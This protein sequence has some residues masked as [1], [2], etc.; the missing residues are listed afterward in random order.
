MVSTRIPRPKTISQTDI[1]KK[2]QEVKRKE[3]KL[4]EP[5]VEKPVAEAFRI[6]MPEIKTGAIKPKTLDELSIQFGIPKTRFATTDLLNDLMLPLSPRMRR[7]NIP[8]ETYFSPEQA[9]SLGLDIPDDVLIKMSPLTEG[10]PVFTVVGGE[11]VRA[12]VTPDM[13]RLLQQIYPE[14]FGAGEYGLATPMSAEQVAEEIDTFVRTNPAAF[15]NDLYERVGEDLGADFLRKLG[16]GESLI[17][18]AMS[19]EKQEEQLN[20]SIQNVFPDE[21]WNLETLGDY[22]DEDPEA[23]IKDLQSN[24]R[25]SYQDKRL[26]LEQIGFQPADINEILRWQRNVITYVDGNARVIDIDTETMN[27]Y[28]EYGDYAGKYNYATKSFTEAPEKT[29]YQNQWDTF[30]FASNQYAEN[31]YSGLLNVTLPLLY[32]DVPDGFLGGL[33]EE[34]TRQNREVRQQFRSLYGKVSSDYDKWTETHPEQAPKKLFQEGAFKHPELLKD[35]NYWSYEVANILPFMVAS[36]G[37]TVATGGAGAP[38]VVLSTIGMGAVESGAVYEDL[39]QAGA[40]PDQA[41]GMAFVAGG[42]IGAL[43]SVGKIPLL[44]QLNAGL[45]GRFKK[46][47]GTKL[48]NAILNN[49]ISRFGVN[50]TVSQAAEVAT[51]IAQEIVGNVAVSFFDENRS[52]FENIPDIAVKTAVA[53]L[54]L[55]GFGAGVSSIRMVSPSEQSG[56]TDIAKRAAGWVKDNKGNWFETLGEEGGFIV[57]G[58]EPGGERVTEGL[59]QEYK[60]LIE[61]AEKIAPD[62]P[63]VQ[64]AKDA[65]SKITPE[66]QVE[67]LRQIESVEEELKRIVTPEVTQ[68]VGMPEAGIQPSMIEEISAKEVR[69]KGKGRITQISMDDQMRLEEARRQAEEAPAEERAAYEAQAEI[70]S[71][72]VTLETDPVANY[73][74]KMGN[75]NVG[76][77]SLISIREQSFPDYFTVKQAR[78]LNPRGNVERYT[79]KGT[80][81]YNKVPRDVVLDDLTKEF[82]MTPDEIADRVMA[83]RRERG[84]IRELDDKITKQMTEKPLETLPDIMPAEAFENMNTPGRPKYTVKQLDALNSVF[85][86]Y[87]NQPSVLTAWELTREL[88]QETKAGRAENLKAR[89]QQLIVNEGLGSEQALKQAIADTMSGELPT[90]TTDYLQGITEDM[91][92]ALFAKV[93]HTLKN[94]PFEMMSTVTALTNA[95]AGRAIPR[96]PGVRGGSAYSRLER[97][98]GDQP[99]VIRAIDKMASE[100]KSLEDIV[101]GMFHEVGREP[102]PVD[103]ETADYLRGLSA[104]VIYEPSVLREPIAPTVKYE[105]PIEDAIKQMPLFPP[106]AREKVIR[107]LKEAGMSPVDIGNFLRANK[108]SFDFSFWRQQAPLIASHPVSFVQAN[109]EAW[110][111]IWSQKSAEASWQRITR[112]SLYQIYE[113]C[114]QEGGDFLRPLI[115]P[116]GTAQW[117]GTE[118]FGYLTQERLIPRLTA[119]LP[120]I[121]LSARSFETGTNVHN[122]LIFKSHYEAMLRLGEMYA[123]GK[124]KLKPGESFDI[125]KEMVDLSKSLA[126]FSARGSL[127][128]FSATAPEL[129]AFF[130]APRASIGRILSVKDLVSSNPRVRAFAWK[131]ATTFVGV[132]GGMVLLGGMMGWWDVETDPRSAEYMSVRLGNT[133]IDPW[134]GY[135]QFLVFFVRAITKT[136]VSSVTGAEYKTDPLDLMQN[137]I[138]GKASPFASTILDFWKGKNFVGEEVDVANKK[139]WVERVAPFSIWDIYEA[140]QEDPETAA[141]IAIPAI[142]GAGVQTY[143]GEWRENFSKLG[144]PKYSENLAYGIT[145]PAYDTGDFYSDHSNQFTGVDPETLTESKGFPNYIKALA[146]AKVIKSEIAKIPSESLIGLKGEFATYY[147]MWKDREKIVAAD[148]KEALKE[149]DKKYPKAEL[150]NFS[151]R[152]FALLNQYW[153]L[154]GQEQKDFLEEH[155]TEIGVNLRQEYLRAHPKENA[156]LAVWGQANILTKEAYTEF[157]RLIKELDIP[158]NAI[159]ELTVPPKESIDTHFAYQESEDYWEKQLLKAKDHAYCEWADLT[160]PDTPIAALELKI[161]N[162]NLD[163]DSPEFRDNKR[164]IEALEKG[165]D[166]TPTPDGTVNDWVDRGKVIDEFTAGSSEAKVWLIDHPDTFQWALDNG[167]LTDDGKTWDEDRLRLN[168]ELRQAKEGTPEYDELSSTKQA[169]DKGIPK[170]LHEDYIFYN[171]LP[172]EGYRKDRFLIENQGLAEAMGMEVPDVSKIPS[173]EYDNLYDEWI[174]DFEKYGQA[175]TNEKETMKFTTQTKSL[176]GLQFDNMKRLTGF[177]LARIT[178]DAHDKL[179]GL[180]G[181]PNYQQYVSDYV[182]WRKLQN[183]GKPKDWKGKTGTSEYYED[184]WFLMEHQDFYQN[185]YKKEL[186]NDKLDFRKVPTREVFEKYLTYLSLKYA[187]GKAKE[188]ERFDYRWINPDLEEWLVDSKGYTSVKEQSR[189][190]NSTSRERYYREI[191]EMYRRL[192]DTEGVKVKEIDS[193]R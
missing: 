108:A 149:F 181:D 10:E 66:N 78:A 106:L 63:V 133:R 1:A 182:E 163:E 190:E 186:G 34:V 118:E 24:Q 74:F 142:V 119:K 137:L 189:R 123:S 111:A 99:K 116:K 85:A 38:Y 54:P 188:S 76:L 104:E 27:A 32:P 148:D 96:E 191:D 52:A 157:Q 126:N 84:R 39:L 6:K 177:G 48:G 67:I 43:E 71:L 184:D 2:A 21:A 41:S 172:T 147:Q 7:W 165:T 26:L 192:K 139:Q 162:E 156:L 129:S 160:I 75:R 4:P 44:K 9:R 25:V 30:C 138:R 18:Q 110:N 8:T 62:N 89:A 35:A 131:N 107:V 15:I 42:I 81:Q 100:K 175:T 55:A 61:S 159:P 124:K 95:L 134:G 140:W 92:D 60:T 128:K 88:R 115:I 141:T 37:I 91:K 155:E 102:I 125:T 135:R 28:D 150:G 47:A 64:I 14:R 112:D 23:F 168:V 73:R 49:C 51:E 97:V 16:I 154:T 161:A 17:T 152:Q 19:F 127:G 143:T 82:N 69:P 103:Q 45:F 50:F 179:R 122:W 36:L 193:W 151:Q 187:T 105:A 90:V 11:E 79:Q 117:R 145:D 3:P 146:E 158:D 180:Q 87:I 46:L 13:T 83:I 144:L 65:L 185:V 29:F 93:Y 33:G 58:A 173:V 80:P 114:E 153:S 53:T 170:S 86:D 56:M 68:E 130:F 174:E 136:G 101:E 77:D 169:Y 22:I 70:E 98:F 166:E 5:E 176:S 109:I 178:R 72:K 171:S 12:Q 167:L 20:R 40:S 121:K 164:R 183:E 31:F 113:V 132:V 120:W 57:P 59:Q 94:E